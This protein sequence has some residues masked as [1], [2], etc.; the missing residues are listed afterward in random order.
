MEDASCSAAAAVVKRCT[1]LSNTVR[2]DRV[3]MQALARYQSDHHKQEKGP[4]Q[5]VRTRWFGIDDMMR[6]IYEI[7]DDLRVV[8]AERRPDISMFILCLFCDLKHACV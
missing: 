3:V 7:N 6:R 5:R 1:D 8:T 2:A 4:L